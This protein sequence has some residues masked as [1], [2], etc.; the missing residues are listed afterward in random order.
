EAVPPTATAAAVLDVSPGAEEAA[1]T[2]L[3]AVYRPESGPAVVS[4]RHGGWLDL[5]VTGLDGQ[6]RRRV[7]TDLDA[8][9]W[10]GL[11]FPAGVRTGRRPAARPVPGRRGPDRPTAAAAGGVPPGAGP[12]PR[13]PPGGPRPVVRVG[14]VRRPAVR[15]RRRPGRGVRPPGG[16]GRVRAAGG[17]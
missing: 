4:A 14:R 3:F 9:Q 8:W 17:R 16:P 1:A 6:T 11:A 2:G 12:A 7:Q 15:R 5:D 10:D 13:P